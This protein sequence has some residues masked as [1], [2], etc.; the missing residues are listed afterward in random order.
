MWNQREGWQVDKREQ[1]G[2]G[3]RKKKVSNGREG[4]KNISRW[5]RYRR[6]RDQCDCKGVGKKG[7]H[8]WIGVGMDIT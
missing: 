1:G 7:V 3:N 8:R 6:G 2:E 4:G 5:K